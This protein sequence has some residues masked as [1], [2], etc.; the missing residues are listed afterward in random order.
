MLGFII[1]FWATPRMTTGHLV[2]AGVTL[3]Y[4][5]VAL[6]FEE[7]DL[8]NIHGEA[9]KAYQREVGMLVPIPKRK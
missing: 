3:A 7:R 1:A 2:F 8:T 9:Y 4:I 6:Q 5:L